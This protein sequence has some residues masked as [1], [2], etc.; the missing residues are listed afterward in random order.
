M[1][2]V[3]WLVVTGAAALATSTSIALTALHS[4][5]NSCGRV[6]CET[7]V[8]FKTAVAHAESPHALSTLRSS[9]TCCVLARACALLRRLSQAGVV[10]TALQR[11]A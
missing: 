4:E 1:M 10:V 6:R 9:F 8:L 5:Y 7:A 3:C 2:G 11:E